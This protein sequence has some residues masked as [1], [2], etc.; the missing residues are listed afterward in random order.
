MSTRDIQVLGKYDV[1]REIGRGSMG[2]V[3]LGHDPF[4]GCNIALKVAHPEVDAKDSGRGRYRKLFFNEAKVAGRLK[5][6]N[7]V[8]VHD[9][10]IEDDIWYIVMEYIQSGANPA[11][12]HQTRWS[13][14][15]GRRGATNFQMRQSPRLRPS[16]RRHPPRHKARNILVTE[17]DE[18]KLGDFSIA[19]TT[20]QGCHREHSDSRL[21][22]LT[23]VHVAG[24]IR[25]HNVTN[26]TDL[27]SLGMVIFEMLTGQHPFQ[28]DSLPAITHKITHDPHPP[29]RELRSDAPKISRA[30][31]RP[32]AQQE[33]GH[34]IS[35]GSRCGGRSQSGF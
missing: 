12:V 15:D 20:L 4:S 6:P 17:D 26:Q 19:L 29:I 9:A 13:A 5:H 28:A 2:T 3:F 16:Q 11:R 1:I 34:Q 10:G 8:E 7:I 23:A 22:R 18:V 30:H 14:A 25:M 32:Y 33:P 31:R 21:R 24:A 35:N 27:F